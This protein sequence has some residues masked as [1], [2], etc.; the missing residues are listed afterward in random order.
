MR[1][2][3]RCSGSRPPSA[4]NIPTRRYGVW[5]NQVQGPHCSART[6]SF[7]SGRVSDQAR[8][9]DKPFE[10]VRRTHL[11]V[12]GSTE[13]LQPRGSPHGDIRC[14]CDGP[15]LLQF[16]QSAKRASRQRCLMGLFD[17]L[18]LAYIRLLSAWGSKSRDA[19]IASTMSRD[20]VCEARSGSLA[21]PMTRHGKY[22]SPQNQ[23]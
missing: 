4:Q 19:S 8:H 15:D 12:A 16:A 6:E 14:R 21:Q 1:W 13:T 11:E 17:G 5:G 7:C 23:G 18:S 3:R 22:Y 2:E 9:R 10:A 20:G